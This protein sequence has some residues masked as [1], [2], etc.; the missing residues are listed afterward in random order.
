MTL[1]EKYK[2]IVKDY[3]DLEQFN[4]EQPNLEQPNPYE[5]FRKTWVTYNYCATPYAPVKRLRMF[6]VISVDEL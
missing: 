5:N 1:E 6:L 4:L 2:E 3:K